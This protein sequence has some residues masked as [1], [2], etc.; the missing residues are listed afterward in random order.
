MILINKCKIYK[1]RIKKMNYVNNNNKNQII[2][3]IY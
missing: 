1:I 3:K 2:M